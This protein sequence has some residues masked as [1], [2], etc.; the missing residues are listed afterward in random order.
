MNTMVL[1]TWAP[2]SILALGLV[3]MTGIQTQ[4]DLPLRESLQ[5]AVP[6]SLA[7]RSSKDIEISAEEQRVAGMSNYLMRTYS[8]P[9]AAAFSLYVGYYE[10]QRQGRTIHS[11][12]NCLPGA[13]WEALI[14]SKASVV[15]AAGPVEVNRYLLQNGKARALVLYWYQG[16]G[17][18]VASEYAVKWNLLR[19]SA[20]RRRSDEALVRVIVPLGRQPEHEAFRLASS[21]VRQ[22]VPAVGRAIPN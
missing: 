19:D 6:T 14:S 12:K 1:R 17:R 13:G 9:G 7:G 10:S 18:V 5:K 21:V 16:R 11:P 4:R 2:A 3:L 8:L 22:V 20:L 15:T